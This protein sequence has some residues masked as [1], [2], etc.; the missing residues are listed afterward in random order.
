MP[1]FSRA[2]HHHRYISHTVQIARCLADEL[3]PLADRLFAD[4]IDGAAFRFAIR[5]FFMGERPRAAILK[6]DD[7]WLYLEGP[8]YEIDGT[9][10]P[11]GA[12]M[13]VSPSGWLSL[14]PVEA[15]E[16]HTE[17]RRV[18]DATTFRWLIQKGLLGDVEPLR[19]ERDRKTDDPIALRQ[20][21]AAAG[22]SAPENEASHG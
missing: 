3:V 6:G 15:A 21:A 22:L 8:V 20:M 7:I 5:P 17:L 13:I 11:M 18:I 2:T 1:F 19:P 12:Q 4:T 9:Q 16:L 14:G 10:F